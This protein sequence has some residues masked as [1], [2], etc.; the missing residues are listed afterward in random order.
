VHFIKIEP[1]ISPFGDVWTESL[2]YEN[3]SANYL[4]EVLNYEEEVLSQR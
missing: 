4:D 3:V 2:K 1:F